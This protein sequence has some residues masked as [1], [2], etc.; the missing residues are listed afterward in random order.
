[1]A[2]P[3][4]GVG[5]RAQAA[6]VAG[7]PGPASPTRSVAVRTADWLDDRL[8]AAVLAVGAVG[9]ALPATGRN[10]DARG[11]IDPTLAVLVLTAGF[12]VDL[13]GARSV[14]V[15]L[16]RLVAALAV[17][18]V[19]L[20]LLAWG[21]SR[22]ATGAVRDAVLSV[23]VAPPEVA[24]LALTALAG[25][26]VPVAAALLVAS[27]VVTVLAAGPVLALLAGG[28]VASSGMG[29]LG[30]LAVVVAA[31]LAVGVLLRRLSGDR[32]PIVG[33]MRVAGGLS[34][35]VLLWEVASQVH[36]EVVYLGAAGLL[37]AFLAGS[38]LLGAAVAAGV[39]RSGRPGLVLPVAMRD[40]AVAA[41]IAA[42]AFGPAATGALGIYGLLVLVVG[43]LTA[44]H[45][46]RRPRTES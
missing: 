25:G 42:A 3:R 24:S 35:L 33:A 39:E 43:T 26:E 6:G 21:I 28:P 29:V 4:R 30:T 15:R 38:G 17:G 41:G 5:R 34:L 40:F 46:P 20:P 7:T 16:G 18:S 37:A 12:A 32:E 27:S 8:V 1:M 9:A 11:A 44:R 23:G 45:T 19:C 13:A 10:L 14:T 2:G 31:P 36:L 22:A